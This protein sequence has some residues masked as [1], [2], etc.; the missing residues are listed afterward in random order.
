M[1]V[2]RRRW[3]AAAGVAI[4]IFQAGFAPAQGADRGDREPSGRG[5]LLA[6]VRRLDLD[7]LNDRLVRHSYPALSGSMLSLG[8][9][10]WAVRG[11]LMIGGEGHGLIGSSKTTSN[12]ALRTGLT[13]GYGMLD[14]GY[15]A[16]Q[17]DE[18][19]IYPMLGLGAG[20]VVL[21]IAERSAPTFDDVL[22]NPGRS[23]RLS[24]AVFLLSPSVGLDYRFSG[25]RLRYGQGGPAVGL[26][27]GYIFSTTSGDWRLD[28]RND[29]SNA[30]E[31]GL[32]GPFITLMLGGWGERRD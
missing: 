13:A 1:R 23:A 11:R 12:G 4:A 6:G 20:G 5:F 32:G 22:E 26:R 19:E 2:M 3:L 29:V 28:D 15:R 8:G 25:H 18:L 14:L 31:L 16:Y 27:L 17:R 30:P 9:A 21:Q 24:S 10:G 7:D